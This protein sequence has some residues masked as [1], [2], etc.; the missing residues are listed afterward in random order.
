MNAYLVAFTDGSSRE[1]QADFYEESAGQYVFFEGVR[2][3]YRVPTD[4]VSALTK[5]PLR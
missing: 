3:V 4:Q 1:V 5:T 2:E